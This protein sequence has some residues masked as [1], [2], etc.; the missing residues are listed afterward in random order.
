MRVQDLQQFLSKFTEGKKDGSRQG[1]ALSNAVVYVEING[2]IHKIV[3]MEVQEHATPIIGHKAKALGPLPSKTS[4]ISMYH[5]SRIR[6]L[7][8]SGLKLDACY[9]GWDACRLAIERVGS[10]A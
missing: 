4:P 8:T 6:E 9:S 10:K 1:N 7:V 2:Y 3:R 5:G